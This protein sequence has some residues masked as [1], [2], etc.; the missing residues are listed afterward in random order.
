MS[1]NNLSRPLETQHEQSDWQ[2]DV[3]KNILLR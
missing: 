1:L 3:E 2:E